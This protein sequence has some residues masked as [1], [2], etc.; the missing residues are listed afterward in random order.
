LAEDSTAMVVGK[1]SKNYIV[2]SRRSCSF[3]WLH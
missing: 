3:R 2:G 1:P